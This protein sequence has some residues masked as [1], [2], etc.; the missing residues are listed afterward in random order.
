MR[1]T[2][3]EA[4]N[5]SKIRKGEPEEGARQ[6]NREGR[7][8]DDREDCAS[9]C[10]RDK[11]ALNLEVRHVLGQQNPHD[12]YAWTIVVRREVTIDIAAWCAYNC[13]PCPENGRVH[14]S[15]C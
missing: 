1:A 11:A 13:S 3:E 9:A 8:G 4:G 5:G 6:R 2:D 10:D 14:N 12:S 7:D 15:V